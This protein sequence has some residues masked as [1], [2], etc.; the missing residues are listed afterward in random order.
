MIAQAIGYPEASS[1]VVFVLP[2]RWA[3][4]RV[5][6]RGEVIPEPLTRIDIR[7]VL[8]GRKPLVKPALPGIAV[9]VMWLG[10]QRKRSVDL[11]TDASGMRCSCLRSRVSYRVKAF[12]PGYTVA[13]I[14]ETIVQGEQKAV[15]LRLIPEAQPPKGLPVDSPS[16]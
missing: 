11:E 13:T 5:M 16:H 7:V 14:D 2:N 6:L 4:A 9:S 15:N 12:A 3:T 8:E 10:R 1:G